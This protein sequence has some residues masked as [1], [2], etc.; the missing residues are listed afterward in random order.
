[1]AEAVRKRISVLSEAPAV[2]E[3]FT[4]SLGEAQRAARAALLRE[5][6]ANELLASV[7]RHLA[8]LPEWSGEQVNAAIRAAGKEQGARGKALFLPVRLAL[9]GEEQGPELWRVAQLLGR[10][11]TLARLQST[12]IV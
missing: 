5:G 3:S 4:G 2:L 7:H 6:A 11:R 9:T 8:A 1:A 12:E 10:E